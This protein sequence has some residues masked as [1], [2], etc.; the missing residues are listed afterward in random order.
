MGIISSSQVSLLFIVA[1]VLTRRH[2]L[3][4][5]RLT[6]HEP[7]PIGVGTEFHVVKGLEDSILQEGKIE[8]RLSSCARHSEHNV[9]SLELV[10]ASI[11]LCVSGITIFCAVDNRDAASHSGVAIDSVRGHH[12][13]DVLTLE[14]LERISLLH[15]SDGHLGEVGVKLAVMFLTFPPGVPLNVG[16]VGNGSSP[17]SGIHSA[18]VGIGRWAE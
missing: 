15:P 9:G 18:L 14:E 11:G 3:V 5:I 13:V 6:P 4:V 16:V 1:H 2:W 8:F 10:S 17:L 7:A 12:H